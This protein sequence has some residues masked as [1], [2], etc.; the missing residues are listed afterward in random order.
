M[1]LIRRFGE[2][3]LLLSIT[4]CGGPTLQTQPGPAVPAEL[5][6]G[7]ADAAQGHRVVESDESEAYFHFMRGVAAELDAMMSGSERTSIPSLKRSVEAFESV[8]RLGFSRTPLRLSL[9]RS[10]RF[11]AAR[12][13]DAQTQRDLFQRARGH[14]E[15]ILLGGVDSDEALAGLLSI[16]QEVF[17]RKPD[18]LASVLERLIAGDRARLL[19]WS[20][21]AELYVQAGR[22]EEARAAFLDLTQAN[23]GDSRIWFERGRVEYAAQRF[24]D[25][26][27]SFE[28]VIRL[29]RSQEEVFEAM[30][31]Q[32]LCDYGLGRLDSA[33]ARLERLVEL[34]PERLENSVRL[35]EFY[36]VARD[37]VQAETCLRRALTLEPN[38]FY[39]NV[40]LGQALSR[41]GR[42]EEGL[43]ILQ[44]L[45]QLWPR[46]PDA[47]RLLGDA[48]MVE[49][50]YEKAALSFEQALKIEPRH[51]E[52]RF[53][54][55]E[56]YRLS[57]RSRESE[58][59]L[60][61]LLTE[62]PET[63]AVVRS[64]FFLKL[65]AQDFVTAH[66]LATRSLEAEPRSYLS[67]YMMG[68]VLER[69]GRLDESAAFLRRAIRLKPN[70]AAARNYLGYLYA[71]H[72]VH[73]HESVREIRVALE[74][75]PD[76]GSY[77]DSLGW[78]YFK[79]RRLDEALVYLTR[80]TDALDRAGTPEA[81]VWEHLG[82]VLFE[83]SCYERAAS[84]WRH[85][86]DLDKSGERREAL[87]IK[88]RKLDGLEADPSSC[89]GPAA[90][91]PSRASR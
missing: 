91:I 68:C 66:A 89:A 50:L 5:G 58:S 18:E 87:Q 4:A 6:S 2:L 34:Q 48:Q 43:A 16:D 15:A 8:V 71:D 76:N 23:P 90:W 65:E 11:L 63:Q 12:A 19:L 47:W 46:R 1:Q 57:G 38:H 35:A 86:L 9:A 51:S 82:D 44:R 81:V 21:L 24:Q 20:K 55:A 10:L 53:S 83:L 70:F 74:L 28:Q 61:E 22:S 42:P 79:L 67:Q 26:F 14:Y 33:R 88:L 27:D 41:A 45:A 3:I 64:L 75:D 32:V 7:T 31:Q 80:A 85:A 49:R 13:S 59:V 84:T 62:M 72:G 52:T 56:A 30:R 78:A 39:A 36:L 54:L 29:R 69:L 73:L 77:L 60:E 25:A 40:L 37:Y 17:K